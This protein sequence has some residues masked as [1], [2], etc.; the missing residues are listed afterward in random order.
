MKCPSCKF[1]CENGT[2]IT[3]YNFKKNETKFCDE[4]FFT[5]SGDFCLVEDGEK[6]KDNTVVPV[7]C[8]K[9]GTIFIEDYRIHP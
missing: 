2:S 3:C 8:P 6:D 9:C 1:E 5:L 4:F 7:I